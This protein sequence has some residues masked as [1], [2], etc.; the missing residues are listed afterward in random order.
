MAISYPLSL[1]S[2]PGL[3]RL[4]IRPSAVVGV[5]ESKF[6]NIQQS[7]TF[8]GQKWALDMELFL[9]KRATAEPWLAFILS[10]NGREGTFYAGDTVATS[11][12]GN[13]SGTVRVKGGSQTGDQL[14]VDG[15]PTSTNNVFLQGDYIQLGSGTDTRLYKI[16]EDANTDINGETTLT[17]WPD[18]RSSP[19]DNDIVTY[20]DTV[21]VFR[22]DSNIMPWQW[23]APQRAP[24]QIS[25]SE[26]L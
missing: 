14:T 17:I 20:S 9:P 7:Q 21:G 19:N 1:P 12:R 11:I 18:L 22:L 5:S 2:S 4:T 16:L 24:L 25:A 13:A 10:L 15:L 6:T 8:Q 26:A 3:R 23:R